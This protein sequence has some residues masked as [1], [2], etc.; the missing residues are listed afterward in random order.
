VTHT[1]HILAE[2][3]IMAE[4]PISATMKEASEMLEL[5]RGCKPVCYVGLRVREMP[6]SCTLRETR[7]KGLRRAEGSAICGREVLRRCRRGGS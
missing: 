4:T 3:P 1:K 2:T 5:I 7:E 6:V